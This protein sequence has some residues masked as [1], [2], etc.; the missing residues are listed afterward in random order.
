MHLQY[1]SGIAVCI[2]QASVTI[3]QLAQ[4]KWLIHWILDYVAL[5]QFNFGLNYEQSNHRLNSPDQN[6]VKDCYSGTRERPISSIRVPKTA[7]NGIGL[8]EQQE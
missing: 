1:E 7:E 3:R 2:A 8:D 6:D 4:I 5:Q